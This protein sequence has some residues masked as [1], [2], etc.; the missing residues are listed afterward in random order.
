VR[1]LV[2]AMNVIGSRPDGWWRDREGAGRALLERLESFARR[3]GDEVTVV[4]DGRRFELPTSSAVE[5]VFAPSADDE[6]V[7]G[8]AAERQAASVTVVTSD[9]ELA[10]RVRAAGA[11]VTG[12]GGFRRRLD[13]DQH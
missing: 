4:F 1:W 13:E 9:R 3:A 10:E 6:I 11:K 5:V 2:D 7:R 12:A 8:L